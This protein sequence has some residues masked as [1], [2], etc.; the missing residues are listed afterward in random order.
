MSKKTPLY[1]EHVRLGGRMVDF[2]GFMMPVQY[3]GVR[4]EHR[5]VRNAAGLFDVSHMGEFTFKG[6]GALDCLNALTAND[7]SLLTDGQAQYSLLCNERGGIVDD[8]LVYR[9]T[10]D[11]FLMVVNAGNIAKDFKWIEQKAA[12]FPDVALC[13]VSF[14]TALLAF[15]GPKALP[16]LQHLTPAPLAQM[17]PFYFCRDTV[18]GEKNC[19][20]AR[21]GYT[22]ENG[23]EIFCDPKQA[24]TLWQSILETGKK[25]GALPVG[26]GARDT[27]RLEA[28][29]S[30]YGHEINDETNPL[31]AGLGWVVKL[32]KKN[33][34]GKEAIQRLKETGLKRKLVG[35]QMCEKGIARE[36]YPILSQK[37]ERLGQVTSGTF[38][39]TLEKAVGLGYVPVAHSTIGTKFAIDIRGKQKLAEV[40]NVPFYKRV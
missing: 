17:K 39:P 11:T 6:E 7:V 33:F 20:I 16:V 24:R 5:A 2:A 27:L 26:L 40:V 29:L 35:F 15:Q 31:E 1:A 12:D 32:G 30:L 34:I 28:R 3:T 8:I 9:L 19:I 38:S 22:G 21:T 13:D 25:E 23:V 36:G 14:E 18:C 37:G 10:H 4:E